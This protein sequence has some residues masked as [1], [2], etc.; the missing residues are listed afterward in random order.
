MHWSFFGE[1]TIPNY[2]DTSVYALLAA[3]VGL[4]PSVGWRALGINDHVPSL[5]S[6][7]HAHPATGGG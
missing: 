3:G 4:T 1:L 2:R 7:H 5:A 6:E